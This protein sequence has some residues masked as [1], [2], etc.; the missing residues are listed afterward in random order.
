M[1]PPAHRV[2]EKFVL[3]LYV[4]DMLP[5]SIS[6]IR[7]MEAFCNDYLKDSCDL[8]II[9]IRKE[10]GAARKGQIVAVPTL[11]KTWPLPVRRFVGNMSD[12]KTLL[13]GLGLL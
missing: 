13:S 10:I 9:D 4:A 6:A 5:S 8:K 3:R 1:K 2:I 7:N 11:V 12:R